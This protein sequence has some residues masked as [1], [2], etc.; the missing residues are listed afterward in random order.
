[1]RAER[2]LRTLLA[3]LSEFVSQQELKIVE[4]DST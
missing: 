4:K 2:Q 3:K 1:M